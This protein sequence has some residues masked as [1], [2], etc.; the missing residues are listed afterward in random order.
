MASR[1]S[2]NPNYNVLLLEAGGYTGG[3]LAIPYVVAMLAFSPLDWSYKIEPQAFGFGDAID[4]VCYY[5][6]F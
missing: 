1:L 4:S 3:L 6:I 5:Y 2:E